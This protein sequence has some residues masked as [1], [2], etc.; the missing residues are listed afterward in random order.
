MLA[1]SSGLKWVAEDAGRES[2][3]VTKPT[4]AQLCQFSP[5]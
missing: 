3:V 2:K 1:P 5:G 4:G